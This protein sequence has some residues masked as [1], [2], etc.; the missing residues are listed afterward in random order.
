M[1]I[2]DQLATLLKN[3]I[4]DAQQRDVLPQAAIP[5]IV[6]ERPRQQQAHGDLTS[7]IALKLARAMRLDPLAIAE[8]LVPLIPKAVEVEQAWAA[9]PGPRPVS[10]CG[11]HWGI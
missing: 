8:L 1:A 10:R 3:T 6:L 2:K 5:E 11:S 7:S 9:P 4:E